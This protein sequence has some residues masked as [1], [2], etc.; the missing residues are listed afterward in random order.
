[1]KGKK[2]RRSI[3]HS[4][5]SEAT[6]S[7]YDDSYMIEQNEKLIER[8][9]S[10]KMTE[11]KD[12][13][14]SYKEKD[15]KNSDSQKKSDFSVKTSKHGRNS[16]RRTSESSNSKKWKE[17][18]LLLISL[19]NKTLKKQDH[20]PSNDEEI[21]IMLVERVGEV[22]KVAL[23]PSD[24]R[25]FRDLQRHCERQ[26]DKYRRL[27]R[28]TKRMLGEIEENRRL[29][30][31]HMKGVRQSERS[32]TDKI[33]T[34]L[35]ELMASQVEMQRKFLEENSVFSP[36]KRNTQT[37]ENNTPREILATPV[38]K[39][40]ILK[41]PFKRIGRRTTSSTESTLPT[42]R[43]DNR[44]RGSSPSSTTY[45]SKTQTKSDDNAS[46]AT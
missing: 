34:Q 44:D 29:L 39:K 3:K 27:R 12:S 20:V 2:E 23:D 11:K 28:R 31:E 18:C 35:N 22:C 46:S 7:D 38:T 9:D 19:L 41:S 25:E 33:L 15:S 45:T 16:R 43:R 8:V 14:F 10:S 30:D 36:I 4:K 13:L 21:R 1:M 24:S 6:Y 5:I 42:A 26:T 37:I 40:L 17:T 32:K